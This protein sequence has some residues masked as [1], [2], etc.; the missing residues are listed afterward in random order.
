[1]KQRRRWLVAGLGALLL[2]FGLGRLNDTEAGGLAH[3]RRQAERYNL[4]A[5]SHTIFLFGVASTSIGAGLAGFRLARS[6]PVPEP[7]NPAPG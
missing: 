3:H 4:P 6:R 2:A 7:P 1:M 5:P